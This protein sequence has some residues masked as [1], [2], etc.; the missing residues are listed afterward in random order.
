MQALPGG[1]DEASDKG[2]VGVGRQK[3]WMGGFEEGLCEDEIAGVDESQEALQIRMGARSSYVWRVKSKLHHDRPY[4]LL[5]LGPRHAKERP[6]G[7]MACL[8]CRQRVEL[9][10]ELWWGA[11]RRVKG[12]RGLKRKYTIPES[13]VEVGSRGGVPSCKR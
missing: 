1:L 3:Q 5:E 10:G 6:E 8:R 2:F 4:I 9:Y 7:G 13:V 11:L 12:Y